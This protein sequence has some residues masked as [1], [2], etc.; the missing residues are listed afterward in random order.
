MDK[1][2]KFKTMEKILREIEDLKNSETAVIK[3]IGQIETENMNVNVQDLD[4]S[5][6]EIYDGVYKNLQSVEDL[7]TSFTETLAD[8]KSKNNITDEMLLEIHE[9]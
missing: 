3:K 4:K 7:Q 8:F 6:N 1:I 9:S 5:L 2:E